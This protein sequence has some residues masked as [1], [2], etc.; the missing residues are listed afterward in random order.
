MKPVKTLSVLSRNGDVFRIPKIGMYRVYL[1]GHICGVIEALLFLP[2]YYKSCSA[3]KNIT[4]ATILYRTCAVFPLL[5][6]IIH[7]NK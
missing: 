5:Q 3:G 2:N 7:S 1:T 4:S 6:E